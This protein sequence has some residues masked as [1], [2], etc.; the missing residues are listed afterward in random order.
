[1]KKSFLRVTSGLL[2]AVMIFALVGCK[3][4]S[5]TDDAGNSDDGSSAS[6]GTKTMRFLSNIQDRENTEGLVEQ[7]QLD[8]WLEQNPDFTFDYEFVPNANYQDKLSQYQATD[9]LPDVFKEWGGTVDFDQRIKNEMIV[10]IW[11][12]PEQANEEGYD[13]PDGAL[14]KW[15]LSDGSDTGV[16]AGVVNFDFYIWYYNGEIF[17]KEGWSEP[18]TWDELIQLIDDISAAGYVPASFSGKDPYQ[19]AGLVEDILQKVS[20]DPELSTK[21]IEGEE[22]FTENADVRKAFEYAQE[23]IDHGV[24]GGTSWLAQDYAGAR[25]LF[26]N[27]EIPLYYFGSWEYMMIADDSL[28]DSFKEN[29]DFFLTPVPE[30]GAGD[31]GMLEGYYGCGFAVAAKSTYVEDAVGLIKFYFEKDNYCKDAWEMKVFIPAQNFSEYS[32][33]EDARL[34]KKILEVMETKTSTLET[35]MKLRGYSNT[36]T[37]LIDPIMLDFFA[38]TMSVDEMLTSM[39]QYAEQTMAEVDNLNA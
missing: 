10:A 1:M 2:A 20:G 34:Q 15:Q 18:T 26:V 6:S 28:T 27:G 30:D 38:G 11:D 32:S 5:S 24:T 37:S 9:N 36:W 16:Y 35:G 22:K 7:M 4:T 23:L 25:G 39:E 13:Y 8:K 21:L 14:T 29:V 31:I 33:D 3:S 19:H 12:S 17:E